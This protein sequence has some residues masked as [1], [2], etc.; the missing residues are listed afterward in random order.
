MRDSQKVVF[1]LTLSMMLFFSPTITSGFAQEIRELPVMYKK[2]NEHFM[3]GEYHDA[4][5][6]YDEILEISPTSEK[7]SLMKGIALSNIKRI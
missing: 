7:A 3:L 5:T 2:A 6:I 1:T 4:I